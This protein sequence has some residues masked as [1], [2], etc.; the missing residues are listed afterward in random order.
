MLRSWSRQS[1]VRTSTSHYC[2]VQITQIPNE[3]Q[4]EQQVEPLGQQYF[5]LV[6]WGSMLGGK[7]GGE[8]GSLGS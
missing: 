8:R 3:I 4:K 1:S 5:V 7:G 6:V 2:N